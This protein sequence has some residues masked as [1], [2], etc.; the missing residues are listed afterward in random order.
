MHIKH[1]RSTRSSVNAIAW[2]VALIGLASLIHASATSATSSTA[3]V[4]HLPISCPTAQQLQPLMKLGSVYLGEL[5]GTVE[6]PALVRCL[7]DSEVA[8]SVT[9]LIVSVELPEFAR[10]T[11]NQVW[12]GLDG[13][14]SV[15]MMSLVIHL[16]SLEK[17]KK[18]MLDF[19]LS[20][21]E[22][23]DEQMN[24]EVGEH[25]RNL[26]ANGRVIA[27][28]GNLHSQRKQAMIPS[29]TFTPAGAYVG[30]RVKTVMVVPANGGTAWNCSPQCAVR[31]AKG[32]DG[33]KVGDLIEGG[34]YGHDY[35][36]A[37]AQSTA[38]PPARPSDS[39]WGG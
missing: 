26:A 37:V 9:P 5:H 14:T 6:S 13:R 2:L 27:L 29:L 4:N 25:L 33:I 20:G 22:Q 35:L 18:I 3:A 38:S 12:S 15:A 36:Y 32:F 31:D 30:D 1:H 17:Q 28:G 8:A 19:Q 23:N 16:E 7:V 24:Q 11:S 34:K 39:A 21:R 10:D